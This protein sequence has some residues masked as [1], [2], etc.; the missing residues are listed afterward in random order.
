MINLTTND[1]LTMFLTP[2]ICIE[3]EMYLIYFKYSFSETLIFAIHELSRGSVSVRTA[4][5][6][7]E[8]ERPLPAGNNPVKLFSMNYDVDKCNSD[9]LL[10]LEGTI[11]FFLYRIIVSKLGEFM[12]HQ[13]Y[14][15][16][17]YSYVKSTTLTVSLWCYTCIA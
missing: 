2:I 6:I 7:K 14:V 3:I 1:Y 9:N 16:L 10:Q 12:E 5:F 13:L 4:E 17:N 15:A 11:I 8:L